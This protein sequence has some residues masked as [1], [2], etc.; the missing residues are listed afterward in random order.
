MWLCDIHT[1]DVELLNISGQARQVWV[2]VQCI[3][4]LSSVLSL[5]SPAYADTGQFWCLDYTCPGNHVTHALVWWSDTALCCHLVVNTPQ[6]HL[7]HKSKQVTEW[8]SK[9]SDHLH[10]SLD[11]FYCLK[12]TCKSRQRPEAAEQMKQTT[13][14]AS[15][16]ITSTFPIPTGWGLTGNASWSGRES[17]SDPLQQFSWKPLGFRPRP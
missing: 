4:S 1:T 2:L 9:N 7:E 13:S 12:L 16:K 5:R 3:A 6:L 14:H 17:A 11:E 15:L 8:I 10:K